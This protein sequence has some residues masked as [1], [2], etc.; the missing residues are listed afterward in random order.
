M[1][2]AL[3]LNPAGSTVLRSAGADGRLRKEGGVVR[4][5]L[6]EKI[7]ARRKREATVVLD[8]F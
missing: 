7:D 4:A 3:R 5:N 6:R 2:A 8:A 1:A